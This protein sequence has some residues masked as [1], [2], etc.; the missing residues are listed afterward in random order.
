[1]DERITKE[2]HLIEQRKPT[3]KEQTKNDAEIVFEREDDAGRSYTI[4]GAVCYESW[5]Q[6]GAP[7]EV[8]GDNV[9]D[10]AQWRQSV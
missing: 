4:Y 10:I 5:Q 8:L 7:K 6:W 2:T 3:K 9:D 1:M